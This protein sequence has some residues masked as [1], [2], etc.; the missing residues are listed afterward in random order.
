MTPEEIVRFLLVFYTGLSK[1]QHEENA[2]F[3]IHWAIVLGFK[4]ICFARFLYRFI[5]SSIQS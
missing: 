3:T 5:Q 1:V 4:A 2:S